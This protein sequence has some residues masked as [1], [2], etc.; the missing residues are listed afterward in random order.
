MDWLRESCSDTRLSAGKKVG[1][2]VIRK[3][4]G[5][6]TIRELSFFFFLIAGY[7]ACLRPVKVVREQKAG[8]RKKKDGL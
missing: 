7:G 5:A 3:A 2:G 1:C 8:Q 4:Y 6:V